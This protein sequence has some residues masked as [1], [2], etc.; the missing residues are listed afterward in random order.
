MLWGR[1]VMA[2]H[3]LPGTMTVTGSINA[4]GLMRNHV[5]QQQRP[6]QR[7]KYLISN[8]FGSNDATMSLKTDTRL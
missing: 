2:S 5:L 8:A 3:R 6:H 7:S 4:A 1:E